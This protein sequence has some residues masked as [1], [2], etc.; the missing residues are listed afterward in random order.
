LENDASKSVATASTSGGDFWDSTV[1]NGWN[2]VYDW[3]YLAE[4]F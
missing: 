1:E 3:I 4:G 2:K